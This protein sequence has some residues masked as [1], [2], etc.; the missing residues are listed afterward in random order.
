MDCHGVTVYGQ[1]RDLRRVAG[2]RTDGR[3]SLLICSLFTRADNCDI[4]NIDRN[5]YGAEFY[6][7]LAHR[8]YIEL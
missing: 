4:D 5:L 1:G 3:A 2:G 7:L 6:S 8:M